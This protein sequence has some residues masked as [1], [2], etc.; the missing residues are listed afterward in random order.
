MSG[1]AEIGT[2]LGYLGTAASVASAGAGI[3]KSL[4]S[5]SGG[6]GG[7]PPVKFNPIDIGAL[8]SA[9]QQYGQLGYD[10]SNQDLA[11]RLPGLVTGNQQLISDTN[12]QLEGPLD[13]A[14]QNNFARNALESNAAT[15]GGG[16]GTAAGGAGSSW[17]NAASAS[18]ANSTQG[19]QDYNRANLDTLLNAPGN[20]PLFDTLSPGDVTALTEGNINNQ[21]Q[22][23]IGNYQYA[24][25]KA[26]APSGGSI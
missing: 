3:T 17:N 22:Y 13:P 10:L 9:E 16:G 6:F 19:V 7:A 11:T 26:N 2:V 14:V 4:T 1:I 15:F 5:S 8:N 12:K 23:N 24:V 18:I 25:E 20:Q 21:N